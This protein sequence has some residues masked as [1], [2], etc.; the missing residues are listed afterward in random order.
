MEVDLSAYVAALSRL[1]RDPDSPFASEGI[2]EALE[3]LAVGL[4]KLGKL[5]LA[6][7]RAPR[8]LASGQQ[9]LRCRFGSGVLALHV[10]VRL[11]AAGDRRYAM[12]IRTLSE[13]RLRHFEAIAN[14]FRPT[15]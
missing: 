8:R 14:S 13:R 10:Q 15:S 9:V 4:D 7:C 11:V 12:N 5:A 2:R 3:A 1:A 6:G